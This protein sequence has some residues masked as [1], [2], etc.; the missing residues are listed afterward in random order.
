MPDILAAIGHMK[1]P[2]RAWLDC[3]VN[4]GSGGSIIRQTSVF[5][6]VGLRGRIYWYLAHPLHQVEFAGML[7]GITR[8]VERPP[9]RP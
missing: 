6:P 9:E 1:L 4:T 2:E 8:T 7:R 3:D 5:D